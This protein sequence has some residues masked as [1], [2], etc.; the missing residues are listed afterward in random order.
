MDRKLYGENHPM[1]GIVL[2]NLANLVQRKG[3]YDAAE[4]LY[5]EAIAVKRHTFP[6][7]HW[8]IATVKSL[9]GGC[10]IA[11]RRYRDAE[12]LL[13]ESYPPIA[14]QFGAAHNR[15]LVALRRIGDLYEAW[16][17]PDQASEWRAKLPAKR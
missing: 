10:L 9:L 3:D 13:L 6:E 7:N 14:A 15:S 8:D 16:G 1:V 2:N 5:R 4:S 11:A 17:K 12:P